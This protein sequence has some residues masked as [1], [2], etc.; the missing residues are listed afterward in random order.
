MKAK[1]PPAGGTSLANILDRVVER[2]AA[3]EPAS[4][5]DLLPQPGL[6]RGRTLLAH[7]W[8]GSI[9]VARIC[10]GSTSLMPICRTPISAARI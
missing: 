4:F 5:A 1:G 9:F 6:I 7:P 8:W 3:K 10:A 2:V